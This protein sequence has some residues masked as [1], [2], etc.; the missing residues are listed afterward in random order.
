MPPRRLKVGSLNCVVVEPVAAELPPERVIVLCHGFG[1]PGTDLVGLAPAIQN[2]APDL[3]ARTQ[4]LFPA[5]PLDL[6]HLG[7]PGGRAW[8]ELNVMA[9]QQMVASGRAESLRKT[10]PPGLDAARAA[11]TETIQ[12]WSESTGVPLSRFVLGG[13]SQGAM[14][15]TDVTLHL[16]EA[17]AGLTILSGTLLC[18]DEWSRLAAARP[19]LP[20]FIS[21]GSYDPVLPPAGA[22]ALRDLFTAA[23]CQVSYTSF[24]GSH[25]IPAEVLEAWLKFLSEQC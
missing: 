7:M 25:E 20:V 3:M 17:I 10:T 2:A 16:T 5:A 11:L 15:T 21:H 19:G 13:F 24:P 8:W 22:E 1:A 4:F 12:L 14:V 23:G 18:E 9:L 6:A